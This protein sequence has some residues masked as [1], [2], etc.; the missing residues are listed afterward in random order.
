MKQFEYRGC[1]NQFPII[2]QR[3]QGEEISDPVPRARG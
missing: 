2:G 1:P 3:Y